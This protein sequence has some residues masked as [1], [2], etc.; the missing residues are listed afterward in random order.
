MRIVLHDKTP[1]S[2]LREGSCP[3]EPIPQLAAT[4]L[5]QRLGRRMTPGDLG[6]HITGENYFWADDGLGRLWFPGGARVGLEEVAG[7]MRRRNFLVLGGLGLTSVAH[8]WL[9]SDVDRVAAAVGGGGVDFWLADSLDR[10]AHEL[11]R[12]DDA[13]GGGAVWEPVTAH[14]R[15]VMGL[16]KSNSYHDAVGRRLYGV[17]AELARQAGWTAHDS[18]REGLAQRYWLVALRAAEEAGDRPLGAN[19]LMFMADQAKKIGNPHEAVTLLDSAAAGAKGALG[20]TQRAAIAGTLASAYGRGGD[21]EAT[22]RA[23]DRAFSLAEQTRPAEDPA[24][25]YWFDRAE[26]TGK[27]GSAFLHAGDATRAIPHLEHAVSTVAGSVGRERILWTTRLA[28]AHLRS[29]NAERAVRLGHQAVDGLQSLRSDRVLGEVT[30][31]G[32]ELTERVGGRVA[33]QFTDHVRSARV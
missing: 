22:A 1:Y 17:A 7:E 28:T 8:G 5:S 11:R 6:W 16:I 24:W 18:G 2:W 12:L 19:V 33:D 3:R 32:R 23:V 27:A 30:E 21:V 20:A 4:L 29:G 14:L 31:F 9:V 13:L 25:I 10:S 26:L 15:L